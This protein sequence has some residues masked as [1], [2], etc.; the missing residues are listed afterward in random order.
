M[1]SVFC[2]RAGKLFRCWAFCHQDIAADKCADRANYEA[3]NRDL[4]EVE[5]WEVEKWREDE[6]VNAE[7]ESAVEG[8]DHDVGCPVFFN[9]V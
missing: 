1:V 6:I 4:G 7:T 8:K 5:L 9:V 3:V 2:G